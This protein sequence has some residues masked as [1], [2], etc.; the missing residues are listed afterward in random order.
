MEAVTQKESDPYVDYDFFVVKCS[1]CEKESDV[2]LYKDSD[3][4]EIIRYIQENT[5]YVEN[6]ENGGLICDEC[7]NKMLEVV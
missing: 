4:D 2:I 1:E 6:K 5:G 3:A 7:D